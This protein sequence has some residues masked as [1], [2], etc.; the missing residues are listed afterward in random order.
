MTV[1]LNQF[2]EQERNGGRYSLTPQIIGFIERAWLAAER[3]T[4][5]ALKEKAKHLD[6]AN[7][8]TAMLA[9][10]IDHDREEQGKWL[11][12]AKRCQQIAAQTTHEVYTP[13]ENALYMLADNLKD[14]YEP[15]R[16]VAV[17]T[18]S[19]FVEWL[20]GAHEM[21]DWRELAQHYINKIKEGVT[22]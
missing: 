18:C 21:V 4:E 14:H 2:I 19:P 3:A 8:E 17:T 11:S 6:F 20:N 10:R 15:W 9:I 12:R 1:A 13:E 22:V 5:E 16:H 7:Y